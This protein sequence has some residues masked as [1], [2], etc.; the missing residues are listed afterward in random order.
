MYMYMR[1][2]LVFAA[3]VNVITGAWA[4]PDSTASP[5]PP[6]QAKS[7]SRWDYIGYIGPYPIYMT[8]HS[9]KEPLNGLRSLDGHYF[10]TSK[11]IPIKI[12]GASCDMM[13]SYDGQNGSGKFSFSFLNDAKQLDGS[14]GNKWLKGEPQNVWG[15]HAE[16]IAESVSERFRVNAA[17]GTVDLTLE[18]PRFCMDNMDSEAFNRLVCAAFHKVWKRAVT[19]TMTVVH[20]ETLDRTNDYDILFCSPSLVSVLFRVTHMPRNGVEFITNHGVN[21]T[22]MP[23]GRVRSISMAELFSKGTRAKQILLPEVV[24]ELRALGVTDDALRD[25]DWFNLKTWKGFA[26]CP[27]GIELLFNPE[28]TQI[29]LKKSLRVLVSFDK[30]KNITNREG[31]LKYVFVPPPGNPMP[32]IEAKPPAPSEP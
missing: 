8:L 6:A 31:I 7:F 12:A 10:Y 32:R 4:T 27:C 23:N 21:L 3:F 14:W 22:M 16:Q 25:A 29:G 11:C 26:I 20:N 18:L 13:E 9:R 17:T 19:N 5:V 15:F 2:I 24:S 30:L 28:N 1:Q